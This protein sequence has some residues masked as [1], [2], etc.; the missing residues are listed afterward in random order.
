MKT[1]LFKDR[2]ISPKVR[3]ESPKS[4]QYVNISD[5]STYSPHVST[6]APIPTH[7][8][9]CLVSTP[10]DTIYLPWRKMGKFSN[11]IILR[12]LLLFCTGTV[13]MSQAMSMTDAGFWLCLNI[14]SLSTEKW[15]MLHF[16]RTVKI[17]YPYHSTFVHFVSLTFSGIKSFKIQLRTAWGETIVKSKVDS[18]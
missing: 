9:W 4:C 14:S 16:C 7:L 17:M 5:V 3:L 8:C 12:V 13:P 11:L 18:V 15:L 1:S 2:L 6:S 10:T